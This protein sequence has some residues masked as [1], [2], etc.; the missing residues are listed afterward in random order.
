MTT[1]EA[2]QSEEKSSSGKRSSRAV[3]GA[4]NVSTGA[5]VPEPRGSLKDVFGIEVKT[6]RLAM[7]GRAV[8]VRYTIVD[9]ERAA[10]LDQRAN[11]TYLLD[12]KTGER[13][14]MPQSPPPLELHRPKEGSDYFVIFKNTQ[15][16]KEGSKVTL[17]V[18]NA[19][20]TH[21]TVE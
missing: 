18:G 8:D 17:V 13:V 14:G 9:P 11:T 4:E 10:G 12:E 6:V 21:L 5:T 2:N 1:P 15:A 20:A 16:V 19:Q 7:A 3:V